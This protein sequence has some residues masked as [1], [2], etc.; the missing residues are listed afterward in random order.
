MKIPQHVGFIM[1]GNRRWAKSQGLQILAGHEAGK[2]RIEPLVD[3]A[4][5][6][7]ISTLTFWAF[8]SENWD[9]GK[10][11]VGLILQVFRMFLQSGIVERLIDRGVRVGVLGDI[12]AFPADIAEGVRDVVA[13]SKHNTSITANFALN[14]GGRKE[15]LR[16][17]NALLQQGV[18]EVNEEDFS[19][20]LYTAGQVDPDLIIRTGGEQ[21]LSGFL[22]WQ[23]VYSEL[24]FTDIFWPDFTE[25][26]FQKALDEY[27]LR[28]RRFGK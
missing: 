1:D 23:G 5:K 25:A 18:V 7:G 12:S 9:R 16:A 21:R 4:V 17:V 3:Y 28:E 2:D 13:R 14:Y 19:S 27:G 11:E 6:H 8:S 20:A 15:I 24:Y 10:M 22:P 26:A